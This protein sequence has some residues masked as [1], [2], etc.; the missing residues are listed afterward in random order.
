MKVHKLVMRLHWGMSIAAEA[1][2]SYGYGQQEMRWHW[3]NVTCLRCR[4]RRGK[5]KGP[6]W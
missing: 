3:R 2:C 4:A 5:V 6:K 1:L